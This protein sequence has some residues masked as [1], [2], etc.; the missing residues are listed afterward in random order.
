MRKFLILGSV[1]I[2][3]FCF[4]QKNYIKEDGTIEDEFY[5]QQFVVG[6]NDNKKNVKFDIDDKY[7][8]IVSKY[9]CGDETFEPKKMQNDALTYSYLQLLD[10]IHLF[11][12][13]GQTTLSDYK[14]EGIIFKTNT[15]CMLSTRRY[16]FKF[17][18]D[19][20]KSFPEYMDYEE[21]CNVVYK[22]NNKNIIYIKN[23]LQNYLIEYVEYNLSI[24]CL[25][26]GKLRTQ[27]AEADKRG[28]ENSEKHSSEK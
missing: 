8:V 20:L 28:N 11:K 5:R 10:G 9:D 15:I 18:L 4:G 21:L 12:I 26:N 24:N 22:N 19:E 7:L 27:T 23:K 17:S 13:M 3:G 14:F 6:M 16:D 2:C 25:K 1:L